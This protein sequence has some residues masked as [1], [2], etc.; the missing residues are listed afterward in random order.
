MHHYTI[1]NGSIKLKNKKINADLPKLPSDQYIHHC[2]ILGSI[3]EEQDSPVTL[4]YLV[5]KKADK[6]GEPDQAF[7]ILKVKEYNRTFEGKIEPQPE[8]YTVLSNTRSCVLPDN[9]EIWHFDTFFCI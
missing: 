6:S 9:F 7:E 3:D 4:F 8:D 5:K 1:Q 2:Q